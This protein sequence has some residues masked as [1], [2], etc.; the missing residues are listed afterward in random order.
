VRCTA[1]QLP[2]TPRRFFCR[3][4][5]HVTAGSG[6]RLQLRQGPL[7]QQRSDQFD[8]RA[9]CRAE[10]AS[11]PNF[12]RERLRVVRSETRPTW[13]A[14]PMS[15]VIQVRVVLVVRPLWVVKKRESASKVSR[16]RR[17]EPFRGR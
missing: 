2:V 15:E 17:C 3:F 11:N 4:V 13:A 16:S 1:D 7:M 10:S 6:E 5:R 9:R 12:Q 8:L 14:P